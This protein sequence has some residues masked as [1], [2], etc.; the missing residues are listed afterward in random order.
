M[1]KIDRNASQSTD[2]P[3]SMLFLEFLSYP[4]FFSLRLGGFA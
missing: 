3:F 2:P 1:G 4:G